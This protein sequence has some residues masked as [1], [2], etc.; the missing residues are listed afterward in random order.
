[1]KLGILSSREPW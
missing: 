1:M